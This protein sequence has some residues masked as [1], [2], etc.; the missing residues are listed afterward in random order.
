ME[1]MLKRFY[2]QKFGKAKREADRNLA[3]FAQD[4]DALI[5]QSPRA[6]APGQQQQ[7]RNQTEDIL[8]RLRD[9]AIS[10]KDGDQDRPLSAKMAEV[11]QATWESMWRLTRMETTS[12]STTEVAASGV[13]IRSAKI[14]V[15]KLMWFLSK[16][17]HRLDFLVCSRSSLLCFPDEE[18]TPQR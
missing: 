17:K 16:L 11:V 10:I 6:A 3:S 4:V 5:S 14:L 8:K 12:D 18:M 13:S 9:M 1:Q 7:N 15:T 2:I